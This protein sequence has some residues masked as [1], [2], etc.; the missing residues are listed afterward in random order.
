MTASF[1]TLPPAFL[2]DLLARR[3]RLQWVAA[4]V[5]S[6]S[7]DDDVPNEL[8]VNIAGGNIDG[9]RVLHS[10]TDPQPD[11]IAQCLIIESMGMVAIGRIN[12]LVYDTP[13][14]TPPPMFLDPVVTVG[15]DHWRYNRV[16]LANLAS[17][18]ATSLEIGLKSSTLVEPA[19]WLA[20]QVSA[21]PVYVSTEWDPLE[22]VPAG[23]ALT[24]VPLPL[25]WLDLILADPL[26]EGIVA[27]RFG[28]P[29]TPYPW[30]SGSG[31][32]RFTP[33]F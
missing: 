17:Q 25:G 23:G 4:T 31:Q 3:S 16:A 15:N 2:V 32:L 19:L 13:N 14:P 33:L 6:V 8:V 27:R 9:V 1:G 20:K 7:F 26:V 29:D 5:I 30:L 21:A 11:D 10:Y 12:A 18:S 24:W 22:T 28:F